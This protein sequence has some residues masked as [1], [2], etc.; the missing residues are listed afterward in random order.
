MQD[1]SRRA[2]THEL[3]TIEQQMRSVGIQRHE[4]PWRET[5][6]SLLQSGSMTGPQVLLLHG[7]TYS[8]A[9][10]FH[11]TVPGQ[12]ADEY[13]LLLQLSQS[14]GCWCLDF[15]GY[16]FSSTSNQSTKETVDDYVKQVDEAVRYLKQTTG[17]KPVLIGWSWGGQ[18]ASRYAGYHGDSLAGMV[19]WGA[20]WG[21]TGQAEFVKSLPKPT[22][23]RRIN[24]PQHAGADFKTSDT[25]DPVV[26]G[27]FVDF[28]LRLDPT[29]PTTGLTESLFNMPLHHPENISVPTLVIH[30]EHDFVA[31]SNDVGDYFDALASPVKQYRIIAQA[32][33][34]VQYSKV[35]HTLVRELNDF[36]HQCYRNK[37]DL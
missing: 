28:A 10:V 8:S 20:I 1:W 33:H 18:V 2:D 7:V 31:Q 13:S 34:N 16:G 24:T 25:F 4:I 22:T 17:Q 29:S 14:L 5:A 21:G 27:Q 26:R 15:S 36:S 23:P 9:S 3:S 6:L 19:Y 12:S 37:S 35:R 11:L 32:D 30:G